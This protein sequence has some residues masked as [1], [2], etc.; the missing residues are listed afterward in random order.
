MGTGFARSGI[1]AP[2]SG[3]GPGSTVV[4][5][6]RKRPLNPIGERPYSARRSSIELHPRMVEVTG[7]EPASSGFL[8]FVV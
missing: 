3:K 5:S 4:G 7:V 2:P 8:S 6:E 1:I